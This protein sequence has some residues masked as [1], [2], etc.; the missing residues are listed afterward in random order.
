MEIRFDTLRA[1]LTFALLLAVLLPTIFIGWLAS[2]TM[3]EN[4]KAERIIEV[5]RVASSKHD[6]LVMVLTR[7]NARAEHFL[8]D[9]SARCGSNP[10]RPNKPCATGL[11]NSYLASEGAIGATLHK[12]GRDSLTIGTSATQNM[13]PVA[14]RTG[15]LAKFAE[16]GPKSDHSYFVS[17]AQES[18]GLQLTVTYPAAQLTPVFVPHPKDL[19]ISGETFL[20]DGEGF[21]ATPPRYP[22][23][24][25]HSHPITARPME[26]CLSGQS[27]EV[28]DLDY[29]DA[30]IIHGFRF[31]P[32]FGSACIM[33]HVDQEEAFAPLKSLQRKIM[34]TIL[35]FG[36]TLIFMAVYLARSI[37]KP[38]TRLT[39]VARTIAAGDIKAKADVAGSDEISELAASF[40]FMTNQLRDSYD[41]L[42][43]LLNSM[44]EG[45]YG[46][47]TN[48]NCTFVNRSFL[49]ILGYQHEN[50]VLGKNV[51]KLIHHSHADGSPYTIS[52]CRIYRAYETNQITNVADEVFWRRDG[53]AIPVEYWSRPVVADGAVTGSIVTF[54]DITERKAVE[55]Q[56]RNHSAHLQYVREE[57]K[58]SIA[59]E[60]HDDLGGT[61]TALKMETYWLKNRLSENK[62]AAPL[63]EHIDEMSQL[64][65]NAT[66]VMRNIIT[67]LRP[68]VL[69]DLGLAAALEWQAAQF[70]KH[71]GIACRTNCV[72]EKSEDC[73]AELDKQH[74]IALFRIAQEALTNVARHSGATRVEI[75]F[76]RS[77][78][79]VVMSITDN[80]RGMKGDR[81]D[82]SRS[83]GMLGMRERADQLG[84]KINFGIPPGG[85]FS[86]TV[87]LP[88]RPV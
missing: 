11:I 49:K 32:E 59:R 85:G 44:V 23:T 88:L 50:E 8:S 77:D 4:I 2:T 69:D 63:S 24:Q 34:L 72:C 13:E 37:V 66:G 3:F 75:E 83:F 10:A 64:I 54:V 65:D 27:R 21:F 39:E 58:A 60:I 15:Q 80:G 41:N 20:A 74:S 29:R 56:L 67:G 46:L 31:I 78:D 82:T 14:F 5:G 87:I 30:E 17:V 55:R 42:H 47:D 25:G 18:A 7:A 12:N 86:V 43:R 26:S 45:V 71:T 28:L 16:T 51:H 53:A 35:L 57:E 19:G 76:H 68:T 6:Q 73:S 22:S 70:Q 9:L 38:I 36:A 40:N 33:A 84:G 1:R 48:G 52:E 61:L 79:E 62:E 81:A